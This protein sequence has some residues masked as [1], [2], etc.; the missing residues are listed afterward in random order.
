MP[1]QACGR[2][3]SKTIVAAP[4][5]V[6]RPNQPAHRQRP[7]RRKPEP[8][9]AGNY[10]P[11][12]C[13]PVRRHRRRRPSTGATTT[14][15]CAQKT[16]PVQRLLLRHHPAAGGHR[17]RGGQPHHPQVAHRAAPGRRPALGLGRLQRQRRLLPRLLHARLELRPGHPAPVPR[18]WNARLRETEFGPSQDDARPPDLPQRR[19]RSGRSTT[20]ST[21]PPTASS[22]AS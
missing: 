15:T 7:R 1:V 3:E 12:V 22:A 2:R 4:G 9:P 16:Q 18:A 13:R 5:L 17:S 8:E 10:Q 6:C 11:L 21:P 14:T 20:T 19:C